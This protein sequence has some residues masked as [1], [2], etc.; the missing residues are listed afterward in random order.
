MSIL[1]FGV[2]YQ[3]YRSDIT[4]TFLSPPLSA[5]QERLIA[6]VEEA[7]HAALPFYRAGLSVREA[8]EAA[9]RVF[10]REQ[11]AMPHGLGH[12]VGLDIHEYPRVSVN[13]AE[14]TRFLAGMVVT[15]EPGLYD[16]ALGGCRWENDILITGDSSRREFASANIATDAPEV[17]TRSRIVRL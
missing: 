7:Y 2:C 11:R 17:I 1:D 12:G 15:L 6:L 16:T 5:A 8:A 14:D 10:A 4:V 3:G 13:A 9:A